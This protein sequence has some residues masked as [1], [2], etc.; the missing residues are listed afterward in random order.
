GLWRPAPGGSSYNVALALGRLGAPA[1]FVG[2]L[3][4]D[5]QGR[6]MLAI[7]EEA[8]VSVD[9]V[10]PDDRPSPL[11][12]VE[13]GS[14]T[15]SARYAIHLADTA[16][17]PPDPPADWLAGA[18]HLHVSSFSA[19]VG[20]WGQAVGAALEAA[21]GIVTR[22][23]DLN[24]R[25]N[26]LP[27]REATQGLVAA[28]LKQVEIVKAS[29][30][31]LRWLFPHRDPEDIAA[32]WSR[33][34]P[35]AILTRGAA[36]ASA[37]VRGVAFHRSGRAV[38][39]ADTVGAGDAFIA[40]FLSRAAESGVLTRLPDVGADSIAALLDFANAAAALCCARAGAD[41]PTRTQVEA[42][43]ERS[44]SSRYSD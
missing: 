21:R 8:G 39:V 41:A 30:E 42:F 38:A 31:D 24:I 16:H 4:R 32:G 33:Q 12:L 19:L 6:R 10:T 3:S 15:Q 26:L 28:R 36:G 34:V 9:L 44:R 14:E 20:D 5:E 40:A 2:R 37:F 7:L 35:L 17:A 43:L 18:A 1:G 27:A 25:P 29:D 22:S 11:S 23:F 13:R